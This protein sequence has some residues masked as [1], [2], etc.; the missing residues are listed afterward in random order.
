MKKILTIVCCCLLLAG[1][2]S[3][4]IPDWQYSGFN[5]LE[6]F[7]KTYLAGNDA[8]AAVHFR[9]AVDAIKKT[10][11][12]DILARAYL[13]QYALKTAVLERF[14]DGAYRKTA[15]LP[16]T[17]ENRN[18]YD[19]LKGNVDQVD[20]QFLPEQYR[21]LI[22][23]IRK[24]NSADRTAAATRI[25]DPLSRLIA[26][27]IIIQYGDHDEQLLQTAVDTASY[28]GWQKALQVYLEKLA[29]YYKRKQETAKEDL[30]RRRIE[31]LK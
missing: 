6:E 26:A 30:V 27:G 18:F 3:K 17:P 24:G 19:L 9:K 21:G 2:G 15:A 16:L 10:G 4:H 20:P 29:D 23:A 28:Q 31:L 12:P 14:D 13:T 8:I 11:D 25:E 7:K 1:C 5:Q 22:A